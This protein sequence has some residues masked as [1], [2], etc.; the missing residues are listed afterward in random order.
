MVGAPYPNKVK[1]YLKD[2]NVDIPKHAKHLS[3]V[4]ATKTGF[5]SNQNFQ[6][7]EF[8]KENLMEIL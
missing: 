1:D 3:N 8:K 6:D 5:K 2:S 7:F 4:S